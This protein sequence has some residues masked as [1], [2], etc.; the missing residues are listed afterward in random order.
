MPLP[1]PNL[2][3][4]TFADL[5]ME[6][7]SLIP[8]YDKRWTN[9]N[10]SDP[11]ITLI[12]LFSWLAEMLI[13]RMNRVEKQSYLT[14]LK[15]IGLQLSGPEAAAGGVDKEALDDLLARGLASLQERYRAVSDEDFE[16]L[17]F[18]AAPDKVARVKVVA[19]RNLEGSTPTHEGHI[20][21]IILPSI[22][23]LGLPKEPLNR[24]SSAVRDA[25]ARHPIKT[26]NSEILQYLN[27]RRLITTIVH[28]VEPLFTKLGLKI[29]IQAK[30]G[31]NTGT[32]TQAVREATAT[33]LDPYVGWQDG[34]GWPYGRYVYRSELYQLIESIGGVDHVATL[35]MNNDETTSS[36][37]IFE[38][39]LV[40]LDELTVE[41]FS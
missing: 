22:E 32:L 25:L 36:I 34:G 31:I 6:L 21:V 18:Q 24:T 11:G 16:Y 37:S 5:S 4:R 12:E 8:R 10:P 40:S 14:F 41:V 9:H 20:S 28:V 30:P 27:E 2:D 17:T 7:R 33:F 19:D 15:L 3:D 38:N 39:G 23:Q 35:K 1:L 13:Y 26:L 29:R